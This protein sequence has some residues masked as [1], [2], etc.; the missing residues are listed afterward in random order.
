M[1]LMR[2]DGLGMLILNCFC[3][4]LCFLFFSVILIGACSIFQMR[5]LGPIQSLSILTKVSHREGAIGDAKTPMGICQI[6]TPALTAMIKKY[7]AVI[8]AQR[9]SLKN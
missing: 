1:S 3:L 4:I 2:R 6:A 9:V 8:F 5:A 7:W